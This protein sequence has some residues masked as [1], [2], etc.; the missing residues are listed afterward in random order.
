MI[1]T[2]ELTFTKHPLVLLC[3]PDPFIRDAFV[4][5][6]KAAQSHSETLL[7]LKQT[8]DR[9]KRSSYGE[10]AAAYPELWK[11]AAGV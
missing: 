5:Y 2:P 10:M 6:Y 8:I 1:A 11:E 3:F 4:R 9:Y 7:S